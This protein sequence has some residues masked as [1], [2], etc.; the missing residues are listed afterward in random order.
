MLASSFGANPICRRSKHRRSRS[1]V[2]TNTTVGAAPRQQS[3]LNS[4]AE[5]ATDEMVTFVPVHA[6][7]G[8]TAAGVREAKTARIIT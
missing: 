5:F 4:L 2:Q 8:V 3:I 6:N 7:G 1:A